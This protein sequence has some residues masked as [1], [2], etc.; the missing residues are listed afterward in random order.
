MDR[1]TD[2]ESVGRTFESCRAHHSFNSLQAAPPP[3]GGT[4]AFLFEE[5]FDGSLHLDYV[6]LQLLLVVSKG[7][8]G[9]RPY[10][11]AGPTFGYLLNAEF[12]GGGEKVDVTDNFKRGDLGVSFGS[13]LQ[14]PAGPASVF[15]EARYSLGLWGVV[16]DTV[17]EPRPR[18]Q[19]LLVGAGVTFPIG[20][21][22]AQAEAPAPREPKHEGP[23]MGFGLGYG[24]A[25]VSC[26]DAFFLVCDHTESAGGVTGLL[27]IGWTLTPKWL[28]GVEANFWSGHSDPRSSSEPDDFFLITAPT[29][30][31]VSISGYFYPSRSRGFFVKAGAGLSLHATSREG[32]STSRGWGWTAGL[33]YDLRVARSMSLT[34]VASYQFASIGAADLFTSEGVPPELAELN[35]AHGLKHH[36]I[37][38]GL[39]ITLH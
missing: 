20:T 36:V 26:T 39:R 30:G 5:G 31:N 38:V 9:L 19:G 37:D 6:E 4:G 10:V 22:A 13:G 25:D 21:Q 17:E 11:M 12:R 29:L 35:S 27:T 15:I 33:G 2:Y 3:G 14:F 23:W 16:K 1:A 32:V 24:F 28:L 34:P 18:N 8:T 7:G